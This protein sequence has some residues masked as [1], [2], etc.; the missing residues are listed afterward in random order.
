MRH[1]LYW[2]LPDLASARR[3]AN[4]LLLARI[5]DRH[6]YFLALRGTDLGELHEANLLQKTDIRHG[7]AVGFM[8]GALLGVASTALIAWLKPYGLQVGHVESLLLVVASALFG[9][10]VASMIGSS[11]PNSRLKRF[12]D[13]MRHGRI[14]LIVDVPARRVGEIRARLTHGHPEAAWGG[15]DAS[16]PAFP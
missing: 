3:T 6:M 16:V 14:L 9:T 1:R 5:E 4:D 8:I 2:V 10:W 15:E 13:D 12:E 11:V 7:A